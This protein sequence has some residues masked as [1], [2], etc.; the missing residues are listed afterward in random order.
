MGVRRCQRRRATC[1]GREIMRMERYLLISGS[2]KGREFLS[3][4]IT[5]QGET[6]IDATPSA[7]E[8]RRWLREREYDVVVI[9]APLPEESGEELAR[10]AVRGCGCSVLLLVKSEAAEQLQQ[11]LEDCGVFVVS[12][13]VSK[14][15]LQSA[16][17]FIR[18]SRRRVEQLEKKLE[19]VKIIDRAKCCLMEYLGMTEAQA[20]RHIEKQAM[21]LRRSRRDVSEDILKTYE[22]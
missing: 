14:Q 8:A 20:H 9:N 15:A 17:R 11:E 12:K 5:L 10:E 19:D 2:D 13:P 3:E 21:D 1:H 16:L 22:M 4:L 6:R 18:V 7:R